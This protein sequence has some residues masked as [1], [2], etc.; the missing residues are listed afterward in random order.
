MATV[1]FVAIAGAITE[2]MAVGY[3]AAGAVVAA[4]LGSIVDSQVLFPALLGDDD[5]SDPTMGD[6]N[7]STFEDGKPAYFP[8]GSKCESE[9]HIIWQTNPNQNRAPSTR[10]GGKGGGS[11]PHS[12][13]PVHYYCDIAVAISVGKEIQSVEEVYADEK[14]VYAAVDT[15]DEQSNTIYV[16]TPDGNGHQKHT[17]P[18]SFKFAASGDYTVGQTVTISGYTAGQNN[19]DFTIMYLD[20]SGSDSYMHVYNPNGVSEIAGPTPKRFIMI[21]KNWLGGLSIDYDIKYGTWSQAK[22]TIMTGVLGNDIPAFRGTAYIV[23]E[24]LDLTEFGN[25]PPSFRIVYTASPA[26]TTAKNAIEEYLG[27]AK[28]TSADYDTSRIPTTI[29]TFYMMLKRGI[30]KLSSTLQPIMIADNILSQEHSGKMWFFHKTRIHT[31]EINSEHLSARSEGESVRRRAWIERR[32]EALLPSVVK[33]SYI[34]MSTVEKATEFSHTGDLNKNINAHE[35]NLPIATFQSNALAIAKR[36]KDQA[37]SARNLIQLTLPASYFYILENDIIKFEDV[38]VDGGHN[39]WYMLVNKKDRGENF[40]ISFEGVSDADYLKEYQDSLSATAA[41]STITGGTFPP[42]QLIFKIFDGAPLSDRHHDISGFY[43]ACCCLE[44]SQDWHGAVIYHSLDGGTNFD[45]LEQIPL[46]ANMGYSSTTLGGG[47]SASSW[48]TTNTVTVLMPKGTLAS[49]TTEEVLRGENRMLIGDEIIGFVNATLQTPDPGFE[50]W[51][52][53]ILDT[54]LRGMRNTE[55][56][57]DNHVAKETILD[58]NAHGV[59]FIPGNIRNINETRYYKAVSKGLDEADVDAVAHT[60]L[61]GSARCLSVANLV[62][63]R[64]GYD[65]V[66]TWNRRTRLITALFS[67]TPTPMEEP[68]EIYEVDF[69]D[70]SN[71]FLRTKSVEDAQTVT[72]TQAEQ[73]SDGLTPGDTVKLKMYQIS[74]LTGRGKVSDYITVTYP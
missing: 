60:H 11:R 73:T 19:G 46:E 31:I 41:E 20:A 54:L 65:V 71:V 67:E 59:E 64:S 38:R 16:A 55:D 72:Y 25:R 23:F 70:N 9:G 18:N 68:K 14:K 10:T 51:N 57:I 5:V 35:V 15:V 45:A 50:E 33:L 47:V 40:I 24:G 61:A 49:A 37:Y 44:Q 4:G 6:I 30:K 12:Q 52:K 56:E 53:Y 22:S 66:V 13:N 34:R 58:L 17:W 27:E 29:P 2:G 7:Y 62:G 28:F 8:V 21:T 74:M 32:D 43:V 1:A 42:P 26:S 36:L 39:T 63:V 69:F 48:D 3:V